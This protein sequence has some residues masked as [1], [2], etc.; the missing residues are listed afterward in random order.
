MSVRIRD[1]DSQVFGR[2]DF[3][4][5]AKLAS[6]GHGRVEFAAERLC[7]CVV[8]HQFLW[9]ICCRPGDKVF[10]TFLCVAVVMS[11]HAIVFFNLSK[12]NFGH[13]GV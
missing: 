5:V 13:C 9:H 2:Y 6:P 7:V 8:A 1:G 11:I 3:V 4:V 10:D 12:A